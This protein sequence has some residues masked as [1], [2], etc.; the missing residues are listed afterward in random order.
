[1]V[2]FDR[3]RREDRE[4][5]SLAIDQILLTKWSKKEQHEHRDGH[6][7]WHVG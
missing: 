4:A 7:E 2:L 6:C 1:M 5:A 3:Q